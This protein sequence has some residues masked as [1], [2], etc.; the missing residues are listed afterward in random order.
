M[1]YGQSDHG[2][3]QSIPCRILIKH[4]WWRQS[5][6]LSK[7]SFA[8]DLEK[9]MANIPEKPKII[10]PLALKQGARPERAFR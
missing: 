4:G 6:K 7:F 3:N 9:G 10:T 5:I 2:V 8:H 1:L